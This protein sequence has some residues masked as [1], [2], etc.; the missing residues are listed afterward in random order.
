MMEHKVLGFWEE[1][2][3]RFM[4]MD[5]NSE[6]VVVHV[7]I[8]SKNVDLDFDISVLEVLRNALGNCENGKRIGILRTDIPEK[9]VLVKF[10]D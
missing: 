6:N 10:L 5:V 8:N 9:P 7:Q 4:G 3:G 1:C 2:I